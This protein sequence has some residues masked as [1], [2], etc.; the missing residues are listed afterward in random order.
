[1]QQEGVA[2]TEGA[3]A[4]LENAPIVIKCEHVY[5]RF[6]EKVSRQDRSASGGRR[7]RLVNAVNDVSFV[8]RRGEVLGVLGANGSGKSTLIRLISTLLLPDD[9]L[10]EVFGLDVTKHQ[11]QIRSRINRV[12]VEASF[13]KKLSALENLAFAGRLYGMSGKET[14]ERASEVLLRLGISEQKMRAPLESMSRGQQQKVSI[15]R[16][17]MTRPELLLLDEPTT[18]LDPKS[19][20]DVQDFVEEIKRDRTTTMILTTHD[21]A[22]A[23]RLCDRVAILDGGRLVALGTPDELKQLAGPDAHTFED[24]FF[25]FV[26]KDWEEVAQEDGDGD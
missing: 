5:K 16:A 24:V 6:A 4:A 23:E 14:T 12:S 8:A 13:F 7:K 26:G 20:R 19:R 3:P 1:M 25:A 17:F 11:A 18:G 22:E 9:G 10:I 2:V 15:A 21:M